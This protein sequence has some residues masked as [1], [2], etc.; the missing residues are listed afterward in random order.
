MTD[1]SDSLARE[2]QMNVIRN[3]LAV[4]AT[5]ALFFAGIPLLLTASTG[6][7]SPRRRIHQPVIEIPSGDVSLSDV[8]TIQVTPQRPPAIA[9]LMSFPNSGE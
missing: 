3:R 5:V 6:T 9:W 2:C 7:N 1:S 8:T 4:I